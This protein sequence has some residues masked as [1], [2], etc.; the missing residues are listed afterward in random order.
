M[1]GLTF[2]ND[3]Y[4]NN[5][6]CSQGQPINIVRIKFYVKYKYYQETKEL[7]DWRIK[8]LISHCL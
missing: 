7:K 3:K 2:E 4:Y 1:L 6:L 8:Y 5:W